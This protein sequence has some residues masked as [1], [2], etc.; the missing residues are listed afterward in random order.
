MTTLEEMTNP[1]II[2]ANLS[3]QSTQGEGLQVSSLRLLQL[4]Q[5]AHRLT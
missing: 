1:I 4:A 2:Q 3:V 5:I